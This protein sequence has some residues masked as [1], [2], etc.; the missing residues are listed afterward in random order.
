MEIIWNVFHPAVMCFGMWSKDREIDGE[1]N[2][3]NG[4]LYLN[5][6]RWKTVKIV[7]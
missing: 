6:V 7:V 3:G 5:F 4:S 2:S 1:I